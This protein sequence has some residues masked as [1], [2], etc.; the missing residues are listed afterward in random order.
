MRQA[1]EEAISAP[2]L[3]ELEAIAAF[4][5]V[6]GLALAAK[7]GKPFMKKGVMT[8]RVMA[9]PLRHELNMMRSTIAA[10]INAAVGKETVKEL[11]FTG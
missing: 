5:S 11:R 1:V 6:V 8:V 9:A 10:A 2:K 3:E 4:P 7:T